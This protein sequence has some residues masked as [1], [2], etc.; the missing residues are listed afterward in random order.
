MAIDS[1]YYVHESDKAALK[2][3][4]AIPGFQQLMKAC[5]KVWNERQLGVL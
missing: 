5:M 2:A 1:M 3:L 4:K